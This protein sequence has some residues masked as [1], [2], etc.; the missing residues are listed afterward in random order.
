MMPEHPDANKAGYIPE[1]RLIMEN[2]IGRC[3]KKDECVHHKDHNKYNNNIENLELMLE[4]D[5]RRLHFL[6]NK[7]REKSLLARS[8]NHN[9]DCQ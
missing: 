7:V 3:L 4:S 1:H 2:H 9:N 6:E 5:H 8:V